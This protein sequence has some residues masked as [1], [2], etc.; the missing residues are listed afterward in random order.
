M[1][2]ILL[3]FLRTILS[4]TDHLEELRTAIANKDGAQVEKIIR[5]AVQN[6][7]EEHI[8]PLM[9]TL[10]VEEWHSMHEDAVG[11]LQKFGRVEDVSVLERVANMSLSYLEYDE[12]FGLARKATWALADIG[13][14]AAH[15][16]L[17]RIAE[18]DNSTIA[19][20]AKKRLLNW[21]GEQERKRN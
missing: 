9:A 17:G 13:G 16:A 5:S 14:Q 6:R 20:Y 21:T 3:K 15:Q 12:H 10:C 11:I 8:Q 2:S 18:S 4:G 1:K 19:G 7:A